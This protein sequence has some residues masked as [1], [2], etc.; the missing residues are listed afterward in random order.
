MSVSVLNPIISIITPNYNCSKFIAGTIE[1]VLAQTY[2]NWE[3]I[4]VDD[5]STDGSY[6]IALEYAK[7]EKRIV[8]YRMEH[9][10]GTAL[11]RNK[12]IELSKGQYLAFLDS[13][14]LWMPEKLE[15]QLHFMQENSCDFCFTEYE[16]ID[17]DGMSLGIRAK[18]I[19]KLTYQ[20][21]KLH[22]FVGCLTV[23]Y[24]QDVNNK[25]YCD[26]IRK[27]NDYALFLRVIKYAKNAMGMPENLAK[28]RIRKNSISKNK[29]KLIKY[30][31]IVLHK[32]EHINLFYS[33]ICVFISIVIKIFFKYKRID[34]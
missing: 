15:K 11:C 4:I 17:E 25:I 6:V 34:I 24:Q 14:D 23:I 5:C 16:H 21:Y 27:R 19:R 33:C 31:F 7:K 26:N 10:S 1:S 8:V 30:N 9:N 32:F 20:K 29:F 12:A 13:D 18:A 22:N 28:Y 2:Q 3:M